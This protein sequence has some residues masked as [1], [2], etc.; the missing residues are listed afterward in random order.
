M[1][2]QKIGQ[3]IDL[4]SILDHQHRC[5]QTVTGIHRL[6]DS[7]DGKRFGKPLEE[8]LGDKDPIK[9]RGASSSLSC[10]Y[11]QNTDLEKVP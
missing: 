6:R 8:I 7:M 5:N 11:L 1:K 3:G 2:N 4:F 10:I 9:K